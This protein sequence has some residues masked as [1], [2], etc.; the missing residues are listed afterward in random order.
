MKI[1]KINPEKQKIKNFTINDLIILN[2]IYSEKKVNLENI[3]KYLSQ[4]TSEL[5]YD[6]NSDYIK[7]ENDLYSLSKKGRDFF[8]DKKVLDC[9]KYEFNFTCAVLD[10]WNNSTYTNNHVYKPFGEVQSKLFNNV[11]LVLR[12]ILTG[13]PY[14]KM[15][16]ALIDKEPVPL[17]EELPLEEDITD[18]VKEY[19][20]K[21]ENK[22]YPKNKKVLPLGISSFFISYN[23]N[24]SE[25]WNVYFHSVQEINKSTIDKLIDYGLEYSTI[26]KAYTVLLKPSDYISEEKRLE[27]LNAIKRLHAQWEDWLKV[28]DVYFIWNE[29]YRHTIKNF[30]SFVHLYLNWMDRVITA[31]RF[32]AFLQIAENH[33]ISEQFKT[34]IADKMGVKFVFAA[35]YKEYLLRTVEKYKQLKGETNESK[36]K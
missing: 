1:I 20:L 35:Q 17:P 5:E 19:F 8:S 3:N 9:T 22:Y 32:P 15:K 27:V 36:I 34:F 25:F 4:F 33:R 7:L 2:F 24:H 28:L 26:E 30:D 18:T 11:L 13:V 23:N 29:M 10:I 31:E 6:I 21:F 14:G 16:E 12:G